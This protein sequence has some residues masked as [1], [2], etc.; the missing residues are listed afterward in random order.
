MQGEGGKEA[1]NEEDGGKRREER[2]RESRIVSFTK[3]GRCGGGGTEGRGKRLGGVRRGQEHY[4][5]SEPMGRVHVPQRVNRGAHPE[6]GMGWWVPMPLATGPS[7]SRTLVAVP[8]KEKMSPCEN[9]ET[10]YWVKADAS[11][12]GGNPSLLEGNPMPVS[13]FFAAS[14]LKLQ[15]IEIVHIAGVLITVPICKFPPTG[16]C[17]STKW[18]IE[19]KSKARHDREMRKQRGRGEQLKC[20]ITDHLQ[21][22]WL[23]FWLPRL[24]HGGRDDAT[25]MVR[26]LRHLRYLA[27]FA[28]YKPHLLLV[29][30]ETGPVDGDRG[31][32]YFTLAQWQELELQALIYKYMLAGV[33]VPLELILPI[34]RSLLSAASP[35]YYHPELYQHLQPSCNYSTLLAPFSGVVSWG[36]CAV[37]SEPGRC[38]RTDGK[39]WRCSREVVIVTV[40]RSF[41]SNCSNLFLQELQ[42]SKPEGYVLQRFLDEWPR[43]QQESDDG[44]IHTSH[45][46]STTHLSISLAGNPA[47]DFSL[48]LST[49]NNGEKQQRPEEGSSNGGGE[50]DG[51]V[52]RPG[53]HWSGWGHHG[54]EATMGGGPLAEAL[55]SAASTQS[56]T[57]VLHKPNG[58]VSETSSISP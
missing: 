24:R 50:E 57:S 18:Q 26:P 17:R 14:P 23:L 11:D 49:G 10:T 44:L 42:D 27:M 28:H 13:F 39:K 33:S 20:Q 40:G 6:E 2:E 45:P 30:F 7:C 48:K 1:A 35:Y 8:V 15:D 54:E 58:S 41:E 16:F 52:V 46:A 31:I 12:F 3:E 51:R 47:S 21:P 53:N 9:R 25:A 19:A 36:R 29:I 43:S 4:V 38:R 32:G 37:D 34:K 5:R 22:Q 56:P 55:R